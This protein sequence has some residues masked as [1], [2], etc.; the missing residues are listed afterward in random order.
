MEQDVAKVKALADELKSHYPNTAVYHT[1]ATT[2][3]PP[4]LKPDPDVYFNGYKWSFHNA[5]DQMDI[6]YGLGESNA[7]ERQFLRFD[8]LGSGQKEWSTLR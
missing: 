2:I 4:S 8:P 7:L 5:E 1:T 6:D 3:S